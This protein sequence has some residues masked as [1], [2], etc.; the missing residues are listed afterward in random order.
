MI[1]FSLT[2]LYFGEPSFRAWQ[3]KTVLLLRKFVYML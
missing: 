3:E 1:S 2:K